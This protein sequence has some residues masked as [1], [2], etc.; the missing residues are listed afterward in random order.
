MTWSAGTIDQ[1]WWTCA[2]FEDRSI[3]DVLAERDIGTL[4]RFLHGRGWSRLA[5]A[6]VTGMTETAVRE[7]WH[8][9]RR[10]VRVDVLERIADGLSI[11][12]GLMGLAY[13]DEEVE[14]RSPERIVDPPLGEI[15]D[16]VA[17]VANMAVG[18]MATSAPATDLS[19]ASRLPPLVT[20]REVE[21]VKEMTSFH[22]RY[23]AE[24]GGGS[25]R[26]AAMAYLA[27]AKGLHEVRASSEAV[28]R[29]LISALSD[30]HQ[31][32]GWA[33]H[34]LGD[35]SLAR[36]VLLDALALAKQVDDLP[37]AAGALYRLG[38]VS[39][40]LKRPAEALK[41]WQLGQIAAQDSGCSISVA[42]LHANE[43]WAYACMGDDLRVRD[44]LNRAEAERHRAKDNQVP[45][46]ARFFTMPADMM[47]MSGLV[48]SALASHPEHRNRYVPE[49]LLRCEAA[50]DS[51]RPEEG[52][53]RVLDMIG[54][55]AAHLLSGDS[56]ASIRLGLLATDRLAEISSE[57]A[58]DRLRDVIDL[59]DSLGAGAEFEELS[60]RVEAIAS[61]W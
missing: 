56:D 5:I 17:L 25:C 20:T 36:R 3:K 48:Y 1:T 54:L 9:R 55:S 8:D 7:C 43:A 11:P 41:V 18:S 35:H 37:L 13:V 42:V 22:R 49:A 26:D 27:W 46:W 58:I 33:C 44:A 52:R 51:R 10:V 50:L 38:R 19:R 59:A 45:G 6:T 28:G 23:D 2:V 24:F 12:R 32:V 53:S 4:L 39:I 29:A 21:L 57:R 47:G 16:F 15:Q 61:H 14:S 60:D 31:V 40:H 34:D 30:L